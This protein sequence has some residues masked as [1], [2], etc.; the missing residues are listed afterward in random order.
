MTLLNFPLLFSILYFHLQIEINLSY[1]FF[2]KKNT[3]QNNIN[4]RCTFIGYLAISLSLNEYRKGKG[5]NKSPKVSKIPKTSNYNLFIYFIIFLLYKYWLYIL[6]GWWTLTCFP[7]W[8]ALQIISFPKWTFVRP[9]ICSHFRSLWRFFIPTWAS[10]RCQCQPILVLAIK[11]ISKKHS[12]FDSLY[13]W[14]SIYLFIKI[15]F[16]M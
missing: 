10:R 3:S 7:A 9:K 4:M 6:C 13:I 12:I 2:T 14:H 1:G 8:H 11:S 5:T 15:T 16:Y